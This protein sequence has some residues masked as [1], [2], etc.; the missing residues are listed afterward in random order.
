VH[1]RIGLSSAAALDES[2]TT[3]FFIVIM[4]DVA[5]WTSISRRRWPP[6]M[7]KMHHLVFH[8]RRQVASSVL[9]S[10][11]LNR[12]Q[13][14][15][16]AHEKLLECPYDERHCHSETESKLF[17]IVE[18]GWPPDRLRPS[19]LFPCD[20]HSN[21]DCRNCFLRDLLS[22]RNISSRALICSFRHFIF[23]TSGGSI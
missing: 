12:I 10:P 23:T 19:T 14:L 2:S 21:K 3:D 8:R 7:L 17:C 20:F 16:T 13:P 6:S 9:P 4:P 11:S 1:C 5:S 18:Q 15:Q 22:K